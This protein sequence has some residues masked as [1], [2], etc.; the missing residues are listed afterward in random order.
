MYSSNKIE[1][2]YTVDEAM[3][4]IERLKTG[5]TPMGQIHLVGKNLDDFTILKWD[6]DVDM[7]RPGNMVDK[8][9]SLFTGDDAVIEGLKGRDIPEAELD[10]YKEVVE[11]GGILIYADDETMDYLETKTVEADLKAEHIY[12]NRRDYY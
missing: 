7:H 6:A 9:K 5:G 1:V 11:S 10:H 4:I 3:G 2:A 12:L 8:F